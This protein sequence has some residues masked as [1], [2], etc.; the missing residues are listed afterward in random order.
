MIMTYPISD[1]IYPDKVI[2]P[3]LPPQVLRKIGQGLYVFGRGSCL[4]W[5]RRI[6][7]ISWFYRYRRDT[8]ARTTISRRHIS[9][10]QSVHCRSGVQ[11]VDAQCLVR[12]RAVSGSYR[13]TRE[14]SNLRSVMK[15]LGRH[16]HVSFH[17]YC[18]VCGIADM[19]YAKRTHKDMAVENWIATSQATF[20]SGLKLRLTAASP[21]RQCAELHLRDLHMNKSFL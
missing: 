14:V 12:Y 17:V 19:Q 13:K 2:S 10:R 7:L 20:Q 4:R 3:A 11:I 6:L 5:L 8:N 9:R 21:A 16:T 15:V 1:F 18:Q